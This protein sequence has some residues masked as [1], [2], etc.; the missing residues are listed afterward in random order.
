MQFEKGGLMKYFFQNSDTEK[1]KIFLEESM[2]LT[3]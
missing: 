2:E 3:Q 1:I